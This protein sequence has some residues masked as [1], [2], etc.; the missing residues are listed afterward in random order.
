MAVPPMGGSDRETFSS[1]VGG[2]IPAVLQQPP[3]LTFAQTMGYSAAFAVGLMVL[4]G[5][6]RPALVVLHNAWDALWGRFGK[7]NRHPFPDS[8][9]GFMYKILRT[10][11]LMV[12][13]CRLTVSNPVL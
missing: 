4:V 5:S 11:L 6:L 8:F 10:A 13:R 1:V 7:N 12:G 9:Y 2:D 3:G